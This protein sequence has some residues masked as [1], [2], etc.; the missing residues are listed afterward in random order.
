M[1]ACTPTHTK[2]CTDLCQSLPFCLHPMSKCG[3]FLPLQTACVVEASEKRGRVRQSSITA[4]RGAL[5]RLGGLPGVGSQDCGPLQHC[6]L[7]APALPLPPTLRMCR[8]AAAQAG[9]PLPPLSGHLRCQSGRPG[10]QSRPPRPR[11][12]PAL[13][14]RPA[15]KS[16][17]LPGLLPGPLTV[18]PVDPAAPA[19]ARPASC[20]LLPA[21]RWRLGAWTQM[22]A[23]LLAVLPP[24]QH[25]PAGRC[26]MLAGP[27]PRP[28]LLA[29]AD[30]QSLAPAWQYCC[31]PPV[32]Q[33]PAAGAAA[34]A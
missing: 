8:R 17:T 11:L 12:Q 19:W 24:V 30:H 22:L 14:A 32:L 2:R 7:Q 21:E 16:Q 23:P 29:P 15:A 9:R 10:E 27:A 34:H 26:C 3:T 33:A 6:L 5:P 4:A 28:P 25:Q 1:L 18:P 13:A 31:R 20:R